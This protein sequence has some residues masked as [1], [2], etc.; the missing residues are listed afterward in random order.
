MLFSTGFLFSDPTGSAQPRITDS[1]SVIYSKQN[2]LVV[3]PCA[4]Q[5]YPLPTYR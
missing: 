4:A 2:Q 3:L 1:S 5:G